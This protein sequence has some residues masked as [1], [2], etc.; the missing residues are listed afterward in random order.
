MG[1]FGAVGHNITDGC[2]IYQGR[3]ILQIFSL[4]VVTNYDEIIGK[5]LFGS[6]INH[7]TI[8]LKEEV[9]MDSFSGFL[10]GNGINILKKIEEFLYE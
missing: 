4:K 2:Q 5:N 9:E 6:I 3:V 8:F 7:S 10:L 1:W